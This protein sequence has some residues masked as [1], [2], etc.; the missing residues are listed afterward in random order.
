ML[1]GR[2]QF[3]TS[4]YQKRFYTQHL[5]V[6]LNFTL[7]CFT[8]FDKRYKT[9]KTRCFYLSITQIVGRFFGNGKC[10]LRTHPPAAFSLTWFNSQR[11]LK[12]TKAGR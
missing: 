6:S 10:T 11:R 12:L 8:N 5:F 3:V 1:L 7:R 2:N 9:L 4:S